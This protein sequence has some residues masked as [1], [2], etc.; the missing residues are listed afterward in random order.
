[1]I[2]VKEKHNVSITYQN[3]EAQP[4][5]TILICFM[6][7]DVSKTGSIKIS[8]SG[9]GSVVLNIVPKAEQ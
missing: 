7:E 3:R 9:E 6:H 2:E 8:F 1:M 4:P 5:D